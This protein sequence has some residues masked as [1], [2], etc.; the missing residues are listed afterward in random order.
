MFYTNKNE[1]LGIALSKSEYPTIEDF[2][3]MLSSCEDAPIE[4]EELLGVK[5]IEV[6][7][8]E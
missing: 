5:I 1:I 3:R 8:V 6:Q 7:E 2:K 4:P